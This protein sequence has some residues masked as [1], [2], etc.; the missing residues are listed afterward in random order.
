M[1]KFFG[2]ESSNSGK[3]YKTKLSELWLV[4][5]PEP[6]VEVYLNN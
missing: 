2:G 1:E 6:L 4:P 3:I 5:N